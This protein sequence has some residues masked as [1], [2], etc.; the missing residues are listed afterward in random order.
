[1]ELIEKNEVTAASE[2]LKRIAE[3]CGECVQNI[4]E[5]FSECFKKIVELV[6]EAAAI[7]TQAWEAVL[8][9]CVNKRIVWLAFNH[10]KK[11]VRKKNK[12]IIVKWF[13]KLLKRKDD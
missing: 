7:I 9:S 1:M 13:K 2:Q 12:N 8:R 11:R 3:I 4:K 5:F 6:K 10:P